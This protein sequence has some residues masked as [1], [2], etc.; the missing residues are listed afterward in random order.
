[1]IPRTTEQLAVSPAR[2]ILAI[3]IPQIGDLSR[4]ERDDLKHCSTGRGA[5]KVF[6]DFGRLE[7]S[8]PEALAKVRAKVQAEPGDLVVLGR[9]HRQAR[10]ERGGPQHWQSLVRRRR[11]LLRRWPDALALAAEICRAPQGFRKDRRLRRKTIVSYG[12]QLPHV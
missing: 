10:R 9:R 8:F 4:K 6:E 1:L 3:R 5:A 7:K 12:S 11:R 2:P